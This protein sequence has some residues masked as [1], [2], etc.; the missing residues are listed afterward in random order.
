MSEMLRFSDYAL[1]EDLM[2]LWA[3]GPL[4]N[5][6]LESVEFMGGLLVIIESSDEIHN[7]TGTLNGSN[8][9]AQNLPGDLPGYQ[10]HGVPPA[11]QR[12]I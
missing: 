9:P 6:V 7:L 1:F 2:I 10:H 11:G 5:G 12:E 4:R 3:V 8:G